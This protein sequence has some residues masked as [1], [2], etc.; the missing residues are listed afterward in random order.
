MAKEK[1]IGR[2][3]KLVINGKGVSSEGETKSENK[4]NGSQYNNAFFCMSR[5]QPVFV[6]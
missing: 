1:G 3:G 6:R 5:F 4:N 2:R